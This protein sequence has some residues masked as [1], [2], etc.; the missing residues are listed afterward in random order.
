MDSRVWNFR[1][2]SHT[3]FALLLTGCGTLFAQSSQL[4]LAADKELNQVYQQL[5]ASLGT[6]KKAQL[7]KDQLAWIAKRDAEIQKA[8]DR[9][10]AFYQFTKDRVK[11]LQQYQSEAK[12]INQSDA[13]GRKNSVE[14]TLKVHPK[15]FSMINCWIS[16]TESPVTTEINLDAV[17]QNGNQFYGSIKME[18]GWI[19][20]DDPEPNDGSGRECYRYQVVEK[21]GDHYTVIYKWNGGGSLTITR[22]IG[23][24]IEKRTIIVNKSQKTIRVLRVESYSDHH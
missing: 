15:V 14:S 1:V 22:R 24:T 16:D 20:A 4:S 23:F 8:T 21:K 19:R 6:E 10:N 11:E 5:S 7:R 17:E 3:F 18:E 9:E 12:F 13:A 2:V